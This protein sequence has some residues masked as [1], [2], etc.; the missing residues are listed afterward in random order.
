MVVSSECLFFHLNLPDA[1]GD[2]A[3]DPSL[4]GDGLLGLHRTVPR[5]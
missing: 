2:L 3:G 5:Q 1:S 4:Q